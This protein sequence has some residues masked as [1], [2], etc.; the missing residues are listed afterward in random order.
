MHHPRKSKNENQAMRN[1]Q[2]TFRGDTHIAP[3]KNFDGQQ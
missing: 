2:N 1:I 3:A